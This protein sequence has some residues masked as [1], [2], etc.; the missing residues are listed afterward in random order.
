MRMGYGRGVKQLIR[1]NLVSNVTRGFWNQL[2]ARQ[3][4]KCLDVALNKQTS[5]K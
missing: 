2:S 4:G 1:A 3:F 5:C